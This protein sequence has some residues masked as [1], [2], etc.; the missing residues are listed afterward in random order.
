MHPAGPTF[1]SPSRLGLDAPA[2][3]TMRRWIVVMSALTISCAAATTVAGS[4][5]AGEGADPHVVAGGMSGVVPARGAANPH[6]GGGS[7]PNLLYHGGPVQHGTPVK[8]I[9]WGSS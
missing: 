5:T 9:F 7:N 1:M 4:A 8:A 2:G 6:G 3:G